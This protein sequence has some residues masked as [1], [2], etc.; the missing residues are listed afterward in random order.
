MVLVPVTTV[1]LGKFM[2][3]CSVW[4]P[5]PIPPNAAAFPSNVTMPGA[6]G[7]PCGVVHLD[8]RLGVIFQ[9]VD[10]HPKCQWTTQF[11]PLGIVTE[12]VAVV[13]LAPI[14]STGNVMGW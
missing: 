4:K 9:A 2:V 3:I 12:T 7:Q 1:P 6:D 5:P 10:L 13:P 8:A 11:V 14:T